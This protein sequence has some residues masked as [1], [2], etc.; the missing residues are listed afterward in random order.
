MRD[1][2]Y[3]EVEDNVDQEA[4]RRSV[5]QMMDVVRTYVPGYRLR[6]PPLVQGNLVTTMIEVEGAGDYLPKYSGN[7]DIMT[8]VAVGVAERLAEKIVGTKEAKL[9]G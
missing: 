7:L 3:C 1:T 8:S 6:V 5:E 9:Y 4:V 2:I